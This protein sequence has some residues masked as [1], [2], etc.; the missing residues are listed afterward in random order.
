MKYW[1]TLEQSQFFSEDVIRNTQWVK[2]R[3]VIEF[4]AQNNS[5]YQKRFADAGLTA[6]DMKS[7]N[8]ITKLPILTKKDIRENSEFLISRG[9]EKADLMEAKTGGSTGVSLHVFFT[10][11]CSELRN[12]AARR[13][14]RWSGWEIGEP[15]GFVWGNASRSVGPKQKLRSFLL[16]PTIYLDTMSLSESS[17]RKFAEAWKK[18]KPTLLFGHAHS[19]YVLSNLLADKQIGDIRPKS[20]ISSSMM[21]LP[22]ERESIEEVFGVKVFDRYGCE[23]VGL[24]ASECEQH[25]GMHMNCDNLFVEFIKDDGTPAKEGEEGRIVVTDLINRAM[26]LIRYC[27]EDVGIPSVGNANVAEACR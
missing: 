10:E 3:E 4:V 8:D 1:K 23:E 19:L 16:E 26:P 15:T 7:P 11:H 20:I 9:Y 25:E 27:I 18:L 21:L 17:V 12:A 22:S 13:H 5:F 14:N 2:I 24:I 6:T